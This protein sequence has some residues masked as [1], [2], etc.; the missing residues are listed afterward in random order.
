MGRAAGRLG[1]LLLRRPSA[2]MALRAHPAHPPPLGVACRLPP[3][4]LAALA[5]AAKAQALAVKL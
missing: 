4:G 5:L 2:A 1:A 3:L